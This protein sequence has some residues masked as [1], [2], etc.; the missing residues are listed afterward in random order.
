MIKFVVYLA[1][2]VEIH[3]YWDADEPELL[4]DAGLSGK[5]I[6]EAL[7]SIGENPA[8]ISAI[9]ITHEH[10]DHIRGVGIISRKFNI[11]IY[12]NENTWKAMEN[13]IGPIC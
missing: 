10:S 5:K 4:I 12:A 7:Y 6:I 2:A 13:E 8:D 3:F 9:L 1:E 11:P